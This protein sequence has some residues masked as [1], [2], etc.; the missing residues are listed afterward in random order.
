MKLGLST[1]LSPAGSPEDVIQIASRLDLDCVEIIFDMP[2]FTPGQDH[3]RLKELR[4]IIDSNELEVLV[5]GSFWDLNP[6]SHY[7]LVRELTLRRIKK[8]IQA[9]CLLGGEI[10]TVH[11][12]RCYFRGKQELLSNARRKFKEFIKNAAEYAGKKGVSLAIETGAHHADLPKDIEEYQQLMPD[13][14][15]L[16]VTLDVGHV[17]LLAQKNEEKNPEGSIMNWIENMGRNIID[18]HLHDNRG[19]RDDHFPPGWGEIEF[20]PVINSLEKNY[21]GP[22]ILELWGYAP[23]LETA[24]EGVKYVSEILEEIRR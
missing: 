17:F 3:G 7:R 9:C 21:N 19:R 1:L 4:E 16:G 2:H 15:N 10:L 24:K 13:L 20:S 11:P 12:S 22:V 23:P 18:V 14:G 8:S 5:H 6:V